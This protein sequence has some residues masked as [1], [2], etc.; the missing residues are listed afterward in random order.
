MGKEGRGERWGEG[1]TS[2]TS[3][4]NITKKLEQDVETGLSPSLVVKH[5]QQDSCC[6]MA[7]GKSNCPLQSEG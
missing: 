1:G 5:L 6:L 2:G 7:R 3:F 4:T